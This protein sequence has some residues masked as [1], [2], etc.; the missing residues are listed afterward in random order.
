[1]LQVPLTTSCTTRGV[2]A[3]HSSLATA[4]V[5]T[6]TTLIEEHERDVVLSWQVLDQLEVG[7]AAGGGS[8]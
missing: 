4:I 8:V 7:Q 1:M 6:P 5:A 3:L 2:P